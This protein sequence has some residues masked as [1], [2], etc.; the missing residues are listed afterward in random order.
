MSNELSPEL[1]EYVCHGREERNLEY[2][3]SLNWGDAKHQAKVVKCVLGMSNIRN[4]GVLVIGVNDG[5]TATGLTEAQCRGFT[6]DAVSAVVNEY[7]AP[8]AEI[9]V[10]IGHNGHDTGRHF[11]VIQV[12]EFDDLPVLCRRD[13]HDLKQGA[14][15]TRGRQVHATAEVRTEA[16]MREILDMAVDKGVRTFLRRAQSAGLESFST[17]SYSQLFESQLGGL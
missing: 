16:E 4:G 6:Q 8:Y 5:G 13:W 9:A 11:V 12:K 14:I 1:L 2:K 15:Y 7:A 3:E 17:N 10:S